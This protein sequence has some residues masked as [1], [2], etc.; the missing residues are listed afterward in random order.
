MIQ[1]IELIFEIGVAT[2]AIEWQ[3][4]LAFSE[5]L[6]FCSKSMLNSRKCSKNGTP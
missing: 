4:E 5:I 3:K 1:V 2:V 6:D